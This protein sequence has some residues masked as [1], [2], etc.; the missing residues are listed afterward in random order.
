MKKDDLRYKK[1]EKAIRTAF[2]TLLHKYSFEEI[3]IRQIT[4][5]AEC[6][7]NT[8]Y[9]HYTD[10]YDL[11]TKL[12][13][14]QL[15]QLND[16]LATLTEYPYKS[17]KDWYLDCAHMDLLLI[18]HNLDFYLPVLGQNKYLPFIDQFSKAIPRYI[19]SV[20]LAKNKTVP[21]NILTLEFF[22]SGMIGAI[23]CWLLNPEKYTKEQLLNEFERII[24]EMGSMLFDS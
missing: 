6:N 2:L 17:N 24:T 8:F 3:T 22:A 21:T 12:C 10:K 14:D 1:T 9:L 18:E 5:L 13:D 23:R 15:K 7:R 11:M 20:L 16:H 19:Y 4:T